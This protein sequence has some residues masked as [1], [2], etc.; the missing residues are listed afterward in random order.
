M[1]ACTEKCYYVP[2][3]LLTDNNIKTVKGEKKGWKTFI[4]YLAPHKQNS[5]KI[6]LCPYAS[7][8]CIASCLFLAGKGG[9]ASVQKGRMNK[10]EFFIHDRD[11]FM[12]KL[13]KELTK[14]Q[15]KYAKLA[16]RL[17]GTSDIDWENIP[18]GRFKNIFNMFPGIKFY[19]YTKGYDRFSSKLPK[20]YNLTFSRSEIN[21][22]LAM[23]LLARGHNIAVVFNKLPTE[24]KGYSVVNGDENDLR[25]LEKVKRKLGVSGKIIGLKYKPSRKKGVSNKA[26]FKTG[27]VIT[28]S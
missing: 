20:N 8:G 23:D 9:F 14:L 2:R 19:D 4:L 11:L 5:L 12:K 15:A 18:I 6:N 27:F 13:V 7:P 1:K 17:N 16:V 21:D 24:Y 28:I 26:G 25:F 22:H 10:S 3:R